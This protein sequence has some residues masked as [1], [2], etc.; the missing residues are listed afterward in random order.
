MRS[1]FMFTRS[2]GARQHSAVHSLQYVGP[3]RPAVSITTR[4][5]PWWS[6]PHRRLLILCFTE[7]QRIFIPPRARDRRHGKI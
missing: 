7:T 5:P 3:V 4:R 6:G 2:V 1:S